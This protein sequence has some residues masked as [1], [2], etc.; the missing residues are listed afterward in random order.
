M[1]YPVNLEERPKAENVT[2]IRRGLDEYNQPYA[3]GDD[4]REL[5]IFLRDDGHSVIGG[6]L[7]GTYW[8]YLYM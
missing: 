1:K 5:T 4:Y 2:I 6:L 8:G 3:G 7:G